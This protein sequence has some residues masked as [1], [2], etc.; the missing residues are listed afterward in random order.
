MAP[1]SSEDEVQAISGTVVDNPIWE[2]WPVLG[3][4]SYN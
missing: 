4:D 1:L 3:F 2:P